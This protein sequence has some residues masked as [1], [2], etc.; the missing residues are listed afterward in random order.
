MAYSES[1]KIATEKHMN[2][3]YDRIQIRVR[4][5]KKAK[6]ENF[7]KSIGKSAQ[8]FIIDLIEREAEKNG[9]DLSVPPTPSQLN[10][11]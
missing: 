6:I 2:A 7:A 5:G 8:S 11:K 3:N 1:Q 10:K 4:K 9:F